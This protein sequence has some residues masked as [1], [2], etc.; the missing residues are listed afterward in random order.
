MKSDEILTLIT[1]ANRGMGFELAKTLGQKGQ[2]VI[3]GSRD[4]DKG[5]E[6]VAEFTEMGISASAIQLDVTDSKSVANAAQTIEEAFGKLTVLI[7]NAGAVFDHRNGPSTISQ[8]SLQQDMAINYFGLIDVTQ[9]FLPLLK[10]SDQAKIINISSMMGSEAE[11]LNP[12][13]EVY[14]AVAPGYQAAKSAANMYTIQLAKEMQRSDLPI[15]VNAVDP[16]MVATN[17]GG[18]TVEQAASHGAKPVDEGIARTV[19]LATDFNDDTTATFSN[20]NGVVGW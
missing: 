15:T 9:H 3:V 14:R 18:V 20:V 10:R 11:A 1:G 13:S 2:H 7:N 16:G 4:E 5:D 8:E 19:A 17:F 12:E 6:V